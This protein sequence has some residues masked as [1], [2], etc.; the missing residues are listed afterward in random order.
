MKTSPLQQVKSSFGEKA[1]LIAAVQALTTEALWLDRVNGTKGL[2]KISNSKLLKLHANLSR[3]KEQFGSRD[4]L[5]VAI[6]ALGNRS[7]D[8]GYKA[9]LSGHSVP[10]LLDLHDSLSKKARKPV[11]LAG[12][13][14][15]EKPSAEKRTARTKKAK[16]KAA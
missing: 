4:K 7:K 13:S 16:L 15:P 5:V 6:L 12:K 1:K 8:D 9:S 2:G 3:T 14:K 10:R 11:A